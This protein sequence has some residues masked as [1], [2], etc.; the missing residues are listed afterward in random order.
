MYL[1]KHCKILH[2]S[3]ASYFCHSPFY[4]PV[5]FHQSLFLFEVA[6][7]LIYGMPDTIPD[8]LYLE[9]EEGKSNHPR[10]F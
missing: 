3:P 2:F 1:G 10:S 6:A 5:N 7:V 9:E 8:A 4:L